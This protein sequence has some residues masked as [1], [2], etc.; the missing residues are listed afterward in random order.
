MVLFLLALLALP[1]GSSS[2][3]D[4]GTVSSRF[5]ND[6]FSITSIIFQHQNLPVHGLSSACPKQVQ[7]LTSRKRLL[8][9]LAKTV[10]VALAPA[11]MEPTISHGNVIFCL[12]GANNTTAFAHLLATYGHSSTQFSW[13]VVGSKVD[14][15]AAKKDLN[16]AINQKI[17]F[18]STEEKILS[19]MYKV[20]NQEVRKVIG[21]VRS[22]NNYH[23]VNGLASF[24]ERRSNFQGKIFNSM[25]GAQTPFLVIPKKKL[26][27]KLEDGW[28]GSDGEEVRDISDEVFFGSFFDILKCLEKRLNFTT[29]LWLRKDGH[30]GRPQNG[31]W[32]GMI[33]NI[34]RGHTDF[35]VASM[36]VSIRRFEVVDFFASYGC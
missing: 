19:E 15:E 13:Y 1:R 16:V 18:L 6:L 21:H 8:S 32:D 5:K 17:F 27:Q 24:M 9:Y 4:I 22:C 33:G 35:I 20:G 14:L 31:T 34:V 30:F 26:L 12:G 2:Q 36:T 10:K 28:I 25:V 23:K 3:E 7:G 11:E 29:K